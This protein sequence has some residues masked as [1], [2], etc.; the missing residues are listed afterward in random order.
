MRPFQRRFA[1]TC[2]IFAGCACESAVETDGGATLPDAAVVPDAPSLDASRPD[3]APSRDASALD[4]AVEPDAFVEP[5]AVSLDAARDPDAGCP[6]CRGLYAVGA[7]IRVCDGLS[8]DPNVFPGAPE[9]VGGAGTFAITCVPT[10]TASAADDTAWR[11]DLVDAST[12][13]RRSVPLSTLVVG[14]TFVQDARVIFAGG[15]FVTAAE[16]DC[17]PSVHLYRGCTAVHSFLPD[18]SDLGAW[19]F[20]EEPAGASFARAISPLG[21]G[22]LVVRRDASASDRAWA[23]AEAPMVT[24]LSRPPGDGGMRSPIGLE[25]FETE[26]GFV[27]FAVSDAGLSFTRFSPDATVLAPPVI[28]ATSISFVR[29][30]VGLE[31]LR[32]GDTYLASFSDGG[33]GIVLRL[34]AAGLEVGRARFSLPTGWPHDHALHVADGLVYVLHPGVAGPSLEVSVFDRDLAPL[35]ERSAPFFATGTLLYPDVAHEPT[36][37]TFAAVYRTGA[38]ELVLQ[39]FTHRP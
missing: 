22:L 26:G 5:D 38:G 1:A 19:P 32:D 17:E 39:R 11:V 10:T 14:P 15:R 18:G 36:T 3:D 37:D 7:A 13:T 20:L 8:A 30:R 21:A 28:V 31:V 12:L 16:R 6:D 4:V 29:A 9:I 27:R 33:E 25:I 34:D 2:L 24:E 23:L 35:P